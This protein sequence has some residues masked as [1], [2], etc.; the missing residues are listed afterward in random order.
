MRSLALA[1]CAMAVASL[2]LYAAP[3]G[4]NDKVGAAF[5]RVFGESAQH[6][7]RE[8]AIDDSAVAEVRRLSG[9]H[10]AKN[11]ALHI[12][13]QNGRVVGYGLV[14]DMPGKEQPI[15]YVVFTNT[16]LSVKDLEVLYYREAYGGEIANESWRAQFRNK[17]L[18]PSLRVGGEITNISG[19]TI[20]TNAVTF[21]VRKLL[22]VLQVL[23]ERGL[24]P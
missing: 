22:A 6:D 2:R 18:D 8:I 21:G 4:L 9:W 14:D 15:T 13:R 11:V 3:S 17:G 12:A 24:L 19:A 23:R 5:A 20:S 16:D 1:L 7:F 10:Y